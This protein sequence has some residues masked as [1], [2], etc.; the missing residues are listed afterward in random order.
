LQEELVSQEMNE[1]EIQHQSIGAILTYVTKYF[2]TKIEACSLC[3]Y[4]RQGLQETFFVF[5]PHSS[6]G[7]LNQNMQ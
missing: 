3:K 4:K 2:H 5:H 6:K 1:M 7:L